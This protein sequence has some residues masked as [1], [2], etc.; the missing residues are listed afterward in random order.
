MRCPPHFQGC[1]RPIADCPILIST[2]LQ[3]QVLQL[4]APKFPHCLSTKHEMILSGISTSKT[5][6]PDRC[7]SAQCFLTVFWERVSPALLTIIRIKSCIERR[8]RS[9]VVKKSPQVIEKRA[10]AAKKRK[11]VLLL[12]L[13]VVVAG[14]TGVI[15]LRNHA[16]FHVNPRATSLPST[17]AS[18]S[19]SDIEQ[20]RVAFGPTIPNKA[21]APS[22]VPKEMVWI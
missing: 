22:P 8:E 13:I 2:R 17:P 5:V 3:K 1:R 12:L 15:L 20:M 19:S 6:T 21:S 18:T 16:D 7:G 14:A 11:S 9:A 10:G 4:T